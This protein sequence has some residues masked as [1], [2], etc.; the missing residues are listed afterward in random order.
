MSS[1][2]RGDDNFDTGVNG[3]LLQVVQAYTNSTRSVYGLNG[4]GSIAGENF[5]YPTGSAQSIPFTKLSSTSNIIIAYNMQIEQPIQQHVGALWSTGVIRRFAFDG[6][7]KLLDNDINGASAPAVG[8]YLFTG[9]AS[10]SHQ[11]Y[12]VLGRSYDSANT[13][14]TLN[15]DT[16]DASDKSGST[17][18][19]ILVYEVEV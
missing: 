5:K 13:G 1:I 3:K 10:G 6:A 7:R 4:G 8:S 11:F 18:S 14:W 16:N 2:I 15:P 17:T 19:E 12:W 9:L